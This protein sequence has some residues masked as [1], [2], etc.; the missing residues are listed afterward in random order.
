[1][2]ARALAFALVLLFASPALAAVTLD[3]FAKGTE[4]NFPGTTYNSL[5][6]TLGAGTKCVMVH[7]HWQF[8]VGI[9]INSVSVGTDSLALVPSS[10]VNFN[11]FYAETW[12]GV[13]S[14]TGAQTVTVGLSSDVNFMQAGAISATGCDTVNNGAATSGTTSPVAL[15]V[16]S[17][18]GDLTST[19][20]YCN[21]VGVL[22]SSQTIKWNSG[23]APANTAFPGAE[24]IGDGSANPTHTWS[25]S[26]GGASAVITGANFRAA[27]ASTS[28]PLRT[29]TG[30]GQ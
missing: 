13:T 7:V 15:G 8:T 16:T 21:C 1:M 14:L 23:D 18:A 9:T 12:G 17:S 19:D 11:N 5:S 3:T 27:A 28:V 10:Q 30:V 2:I 24:D 22:S 4:V 29:R 20:I 6:I 25:D 26:I